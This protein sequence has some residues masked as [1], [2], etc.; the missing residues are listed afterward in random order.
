MPSPKKVKRMIPGREAVPGPTPSKKSKGRTWTGKRWHVGLDSLSRAG[1]S[2]SPSP[3]E[4]EAGGRQGAPKEGG[5][6]A[7]QLL[8]GPFCPTPACQESG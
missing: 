7:P 4:T 5:P 1:K 3:R 6:G 2:S 8:E